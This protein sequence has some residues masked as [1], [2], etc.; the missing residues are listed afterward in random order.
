M[1]ITVPLSGG[2]PHLSQRDSLVELLKVQM[3]YVHSLSM[4]IH[5]NKG[6][7][8]LYAKR[9]SPLATSRELPDPTLVRVMFNGTPHYLFE[10]CSQRF[11]F[12]LRPLS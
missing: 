5:V 3:T 8:H 2:V 9:L 1:R 11:F 6:P 12:R 7:T 4:V 10:H